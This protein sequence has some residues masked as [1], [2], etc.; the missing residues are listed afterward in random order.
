MRAE[1]LG[2]GGKRR[3]PAVR[4]GAIRNEL[5]EDRLPSDGCGVWDSDYHYITVGGCGC[6]AGRLL[7]GY[8]SDSSDCGAGRIDRTYRIV[9]VIGY[10]LR[11]AVRADRS[12]PYRS[13]FGSS[14]RCGAGLDCSPRMFSLIKDEG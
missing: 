4:A 6:G 13:L 3:A 8:S 11:I 12:D 2:L 10:S 7:I 1:G 9:I 14:L 5:D